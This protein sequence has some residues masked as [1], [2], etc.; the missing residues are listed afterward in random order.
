MVD[1]ND[2]KRYFDIK[3]RETSAYGG[4]AS[5]NETIFQKCTREHWK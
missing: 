5:Y 3:F 4:E 2:D 1:L